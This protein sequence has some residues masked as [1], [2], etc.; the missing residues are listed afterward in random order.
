MA[1]QGQSK[2]RTMGFLQVCCKI[3]LSVGQAIHLLTVKLILLRVQESEQVGNQ[4][5]EWLKLVM[6]GSDSSVVIAPFD[7]IQWDDRNTPGLTFCNPI[8]KVKDPSVRTI[9]GSSLFMLCISRAQ[10][11]I[12]C[13]SN[14]APLL[15]CCA[16]CHILQ[17]QEFS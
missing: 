11:N 9:F 6:E 13:A 10:L 1:N 7:V 3:S 15:D 2:K 12:Q 16:K 17:D 14:Y 5:K 8:D 4:L